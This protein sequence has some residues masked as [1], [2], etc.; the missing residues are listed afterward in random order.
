VRDDQVVRGITSTQD[1]ALFR[2]DIDRVMHAQYPA[3]TAQAFEVHVWK[4]GGEM[5]YGSVSSNPASAIALSLAAQSRRLN[6]RRQ[7]CVEH[8]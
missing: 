4:A 6:R 2:F 7:E 1:E 8:A 5:N 3:P